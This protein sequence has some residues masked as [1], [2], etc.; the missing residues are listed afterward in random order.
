MDQAGRNIRGLSRRALSRSGMRRL[1]LGIG[2][3]VV[4]GCF[5]IA[6]ALSTG[7]IH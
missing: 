3:L 7:A 1:I 6:Y 5:A 4:V 2:G